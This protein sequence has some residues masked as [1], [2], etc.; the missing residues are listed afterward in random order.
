MDLSKARDVSPHSSAYIG[1]ERDL[2]EQFSLS[3]RGEVGVVCMCSN[4][5]P[6][7][8]ISGTQWVGTL[9]VKPARVLSSDK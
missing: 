1:L 5:N 4:P 2:R 6:E 9:S 8:N 7:L 3:N